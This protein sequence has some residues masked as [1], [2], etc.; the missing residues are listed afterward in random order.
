[1]GPTHYGLYH[2]NVMKHLGHIVDCWLNS[3]VSLKDDLI[4]TKNTP[5]IRIVF[6]IWYNFHLLPP[7]V[8]NLYRSTH[9]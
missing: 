6:Q 1:M 8:P 2:D 5:C 9:L 7:R 4:H 3:Q